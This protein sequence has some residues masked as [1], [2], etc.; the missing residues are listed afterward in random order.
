MNTLGKIFVFL[1]FIMSIM[2]M[3][4]AAAVYSTQKTWHTKAQQLQTELGKA[5]ENFNA[6][7]AQRNRLESELKAQV[8][9]AQQQVR[10]LETERVAL[11]SR[12]Q[13]IQG[14]LDQ[15]R[16]ERREATAAVASTQAVNVGLAEENTKI[17]SDIRVAQQSTDEAFAKALTATE[18]LQQTAG[19]LENALERKQELQKEAANMSMVIRDAGLRPTDEVKPSVDG[20]VTAIRRQGAQTLVQV[21]IGA[22][23]GL[24]LGH[25]V[26]VFRGTKYL[27]RVEILKTAP[28]AS[29]GRV[30]PKFLEGHIQE[31]DRVATR[32]RIR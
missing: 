10:K 3:S 6:L 32:L 1:V 9:A 13:A 15:L 25:T 12:N 30:D 16:E 24:K 7:Q 28:D 11:D 5:T 22:D 4:L 8:L 20:L 26:E 31:G 19:Q 29:I 23:D 17:R 2:F 27:G 18:E 14:E 21:S